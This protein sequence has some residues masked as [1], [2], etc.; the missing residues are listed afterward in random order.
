MTARECEKR[1]RQQA[2]PQEAAPAA[3]AKA[4]T[5]GI[6]GQKIGGGPK[7][8]YM[9]EIDG[10]LREIRVCPFCFLKVVLEVRA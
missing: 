10:Q 9:P 3:E 1:G 5:C 7:L 4:E 6:C 2:P 8:V